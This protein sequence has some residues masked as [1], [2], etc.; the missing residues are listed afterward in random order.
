MHRVSS[1]D[2]SMLTYEWLAVSRHAWGS[3]D[4]KIAVC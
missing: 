3:D 1:S 4:D 2:I